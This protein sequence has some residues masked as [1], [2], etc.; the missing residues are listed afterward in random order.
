MR[1]AGP[2]TMRVE[3][4][5]EQSRPPRRA[6]GGAA[7]PSSARWRPSPDCRSSA[8]T[9]IGGPFHSA[10]P[11]DAWS[12]AGSSRWRPDRRRQFWVMFP[13]LPGDTA[14][15]TIV[16]PGLSTHAR[17]A[18]VR[19]IGRGPDGAARSSAEPLVPG[20]RILSESWLLTG[21]TPAARGPEAHAY[22]SD[23]N[24]GTLEDLRDGRRGSARPARR[25]DPDRARRVRRHHG[26]VGFGQVDADEPDR[27]VSTRRPKGAIS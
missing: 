16:A 10:M 18:G 17:R 23:R 21:P 12:G 11:R 7:S 19:R 2:D 22:A 9:G 3:L 20:C 27:A 25:L 15:V 1:R 26:P 24:A 13:A 6:G 5:G 4:I 8:R 14:R